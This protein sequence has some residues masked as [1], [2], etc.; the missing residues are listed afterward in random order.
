MSTGSHTLRV[1][2]WNKVQEQLAAMACTP[3]GRQDL[4][5]LLP[6]PN[7][8]DQC[9]ALE[10]AQ[11]C[12]ALLERGERLPLRPVVDLEP[13]L[14]RATPEGVQ[15]DGEELALAG[16]FCQLCTELASFARSLPEGSVH[17]FHLLERI[18]PAPEF[19]RSVAKALES[20]GT[21]RDS[22]TP[23]LAKLIRLRQS[24]ESEL[25]ATLEKTA[26]AVSP[27]SV[28]TQREG[29]YVVSVP[30]RYKAQV[31]GLVHDRSQ[32]GATYFIE[33]LSTLDA[34]NRLRAAE[35]DIRHEKAAILRSLSAQ[36]RELVPALR[37]N[38]QDMG[39][40][41]VAWTKSHW[42]ARL[43]GSVPHRTPESRFELRR[44]RHPLLVL[45][46]LAET[47]NLSDAE[48]Q[49]IPF[50]LSLG[51]GQRSLVISGPNTGGKTV[52]LKSVGLAVLLTQ[53]GVPG[54]FSP[55]SVVGD[56]D[57]VFAD[58][59]DDQSL[60]LSLS[61]FSAHLKH[62][63]EACRQATART[64][65]LLDELGVG[66]DPEEGGALALAVLES[67]LARGATV[68]VTTHHPALKSMDA[69]DGVT[70][71]AFAFHEEKLTP[72]YEL[73]VGRP[74]RSYALEVAERLG[75]PSNVVTRAHGLVSE[76]SRDLSSLLDRLSRREREVGE[77]SA[78][79]AE[80]ESELDQ[81]LT[82]NR[83]ADARWRKVSG[84]AEALARSQAES[85]VHET[86]REVEH[87][88]KEIRQREAHPETIKTAHQT[89]ADLSRKVRASETS[90]AD[91]QL[92]PGQRVRL[93][94]LGTVG[95]VERISTDGQRVSVRIGKVTY[96]VSPDRLTRE[97]DEKAKASR[98]PGGAPAAQEAQEVD[99]RGLSADEAVFE[100]ET[101]LNSLISAGGTTLRVIHGMGTGVLK[102][103]ITS[104][105]K[106]Q[107]NRATYRKGEPG[108][109]SSG[110]TVV[111]LK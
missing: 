6:F 77:L 3:S 47:K 15:L 13:I 61:T 110:V 23:Q 16:D 52:C 97:G 100:V 34:G 74:G 98:A 111:T 69:E 19:A 104:W 85:I 12:L 83:E 28:V 27:D 9:R 81:L 68:M 14:D 60:A 91:T 93:V 55:D 66:T 109:G 103:E 106:R 78:R 67:L 105:L 41:D 75:F 24:L 22:A 76:S 31:P 39:Q 20:D 96:T 107:S 79:L 82:A 25:L 51:A 57:A 21:V 88:V 86:R 80:K 99:V 108:E 7:Y 2:E 4:G 71:A 54:T 101:A 35:A 8:Q 70:H 64:L 32:S 5:A 62:V 30:D 37:G 33:P 26:H 89:L 1:L 50:P 43:G 44:A 94:D 40:L 56:F 58:I 29:R 63:G 48:A 17:L 90:E 92:S 38:M 49:V 42:G 10:L 45:Q 46:K 53:S 102:R 36:L 59:G 72:T 84:K 87:L 73:V 11:E 95:E 18:V 65:V